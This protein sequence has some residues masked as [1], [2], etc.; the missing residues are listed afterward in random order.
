[1][2]LIDC[3][4]QEI[5]LVSKLCHLRSRV[6]GT[7]MKLFEQWKSRFERTLFCEKCSNTQF[8]W[9]TMLRSKTQK[10][11]KNL[12]LNNFNTMVSHDFN[13]TLFSPR[14]HNW[15]A[16]ICFCACICLLSQTFCLVCY[17]LCV[18]Q[19]LAFHRDIGDIV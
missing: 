7:V 8:F 18:E 12:T 16:C 13:M 2:P 5:K 3:E 6:V 14:C 1:M 10:N 11:A 4:P 9:S 15:L 17:R 19:L